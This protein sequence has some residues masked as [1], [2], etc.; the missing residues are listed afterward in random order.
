MF[1][2]IRVCVF[3]D[4]WLSL[5]PQKNGG[6]Q[7]PPLEAPETLG[8]PPVP[9]FPRFIFTDTFGMYGNPGEVAQ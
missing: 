1:L 5:F 2:N 8:V 3:S 9:P 6:V 4:I 7:V